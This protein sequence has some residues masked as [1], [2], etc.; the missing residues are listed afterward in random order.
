MINAAIVG[1]GRWGRRLV[2]SVQ[3]DGAPIGSK[4]RFSR[5][6]VRTPANAKDYAAGQKLIL[7]SSLEDAL[8]DRS[9]DAIVL[10]TPHD[11]H[12]SQIVAAASAKKHVFVEKPL[13]FKRA[14]AEAAVLSTQKN[15]VVLAVGYN[16]RF[17]PAARKLKEEI[18]KGSFGNLLR[19]EGN[20]SNNSGLNYREGMWRATE[21]GVKAALSAMGVHILDF[22]IHLCGPIDSVRTTSTRRSM[23]VD[24]DDVVCVNL[25]FKNGALSTL[26]TMLTTPRQWRI[27]IFGT[28]QWAHMRD[29]HLLDLCG[30]SGVVETHNFEIV[31]TLRL[32]L[33][34]FADAISS[35]IAYAIS[36]AEALHGVAALEA[37]LES[38][39]NGGTLVVVPSPAAQ[40]SRPN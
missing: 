31:D 30:S 25:T 39:A 10:A 38:A 40:H 8:S 7:T 37:I 2:D 17:L 27:Q 15:D 23:P 11:E 16:R 26:S 4:L 28:S 9:I 12:P 18:A 14:E 21:S 22:F 32:E 20:F 33:E 5:A 3:K 36:P 29:E 24:A 19:L 35:R 1:L 13:A 34:A 6:V